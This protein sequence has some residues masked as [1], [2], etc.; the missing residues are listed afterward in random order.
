[1]SENVKYQEL[2]LT[3]KWKLNWFIGIKK[4]METFRNKGIIV[5]NHVELNF[6]FDKN[7]NWKEGSFWNRRNI[8]YDKTMGKAST[9]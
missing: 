1:M 9:I 5:Q 2:Y 4:I 6:S 8:F 3:F 7:L